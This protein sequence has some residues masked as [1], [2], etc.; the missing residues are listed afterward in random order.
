MRYNSDALL[1]PSSITLETLYR[2]Q[3]LIN[4][5]CLLGIPSYKQL[6]GTGAKYVYVLFSNLVRLRGN[7][8]K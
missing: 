2:S 6:L 3:D 1:Q 8:Y 7:L 4:S 5:L